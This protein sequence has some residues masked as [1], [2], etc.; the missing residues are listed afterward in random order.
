ME[1]R[2]TRRQFLKTSGLLSL[3]VLLS[4]QSCESLW[5]PNPEPSQPVLIFEQLSSGCASEEE[6]ATLQGGKGKITFEGQV[7][8]P[9]P[10][11]DLAA[12]LVVM[13]CGPTERCPNTYEIAI[14]SKAQEGYC[15]ECLGRASYR[16]E[17]RHLAPGTY[18]IG[19]THDGRHVVVA[20]LEVE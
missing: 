3:G 10:C 16:G 20:Q 9:T 19:I 18:H 12:E 17:L 13:R 2:L 6:E 1:A 15:I 8:T 4:L 14:T 7:A 5:N 11:Y